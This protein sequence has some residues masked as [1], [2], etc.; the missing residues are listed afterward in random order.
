[1]GPRRQGIGGEIL[2]KDLDYAT[3]LKNRGYIVDPDPRYRG[4]GKRIS[5]G[6]QVVRPHS[7]LGYTN[8]SSADQVREE[9]MAN[10]QYLRDLGYTGFR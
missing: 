10:I 5:R 4:S 2:V 9:F 7:R 1:V 3:F 8:L 6:D